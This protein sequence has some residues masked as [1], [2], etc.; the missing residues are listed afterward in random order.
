M[1]S[2]ELYFGYG[3]NLNEEDWNSSGNYLPWKEALEVHK[4]G[5]LLDYRPLYHYYS[6]GRKG[7]ALD[8]K[9]V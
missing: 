3:S 9:P 6:H 8:I 1:I 5:I 7:G 4:A 2:T